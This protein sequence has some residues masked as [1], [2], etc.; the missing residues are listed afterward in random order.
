MGLSIHTNFASMTTQNQLNS[1]NKMLG[2]A[3][4]R[5]GTGLRINSAADDAAGL[6]IATRLQAQSNGQKVGMRNAQDAISMIQTAEGAM[7]EMTNITQRMKDLATQAANGTNSDKDISAMDAEF[8]ELGKELGNIRDNT[9]FG[10][11]A[12]L[13]SS[14]KFEAGAVSFQIGASA[15]EK[16]DL[17]ASTQVKAVNTAITSAAAVTLSSGN[18][19]AQITAMD[20]MLEKIGEARSTFGANINRLEHTVNN[21]SNMKENTDMANGRIMDADFAQESTNMTKNQMLMQ[22]GMSVLS[23]S[24]QMTGMVTGL[25]R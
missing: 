4:Q 16:L 17:N 25:L 9:T 7:D 14:G 12:L 19:T 5:L 2:T 24:N 1:T 21:L 8:K 10:G 23:N 3:M 20:S 15:T 6:Q 22:A 13:K 11:T 18:A